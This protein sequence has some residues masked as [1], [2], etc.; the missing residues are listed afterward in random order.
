MFIYFVKYEGKFFVCI[1]LPDLMIFYA[2]FDYIIYEK[3]QVGNVQEKE[4][5]ERNP[6]SK[7]RGGKN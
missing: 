2:K 6:H 3:V 4:Q 5:S 7:N 1:K